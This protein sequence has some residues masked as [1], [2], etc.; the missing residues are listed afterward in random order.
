MADKASV[1]LLVTILFLVTII[2]VFAMKY[3][4]T[5]RQA[6]LRIASEDGYRALADRTVKAQ[7]TGAETLRAINNALAQ[8]E[9]RLAKV[10]KVLQEV[11]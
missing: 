7:E 2:L 11:E 5:T 4:A 9:A 6:S 8:I 1:F 3:V 10:E